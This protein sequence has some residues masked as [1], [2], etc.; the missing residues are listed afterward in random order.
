MCV[1]FQPSGFRLMM[2]VGTML[3]EAIVVCHDEDRIAAC[4]S[5]TKTREITLP[6]LPQGDAG[7]LQLRPVQYSIAV[8]PVSTWRWVDSY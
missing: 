2:D 6:A 3:M 1:V 7:L 5:I 4:F 8:W